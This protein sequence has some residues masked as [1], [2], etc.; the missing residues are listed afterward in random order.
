MTTQGIAGSTILLNTAERVGELLARAQGNSG[1]DKPIQILRP[2]IGIYL[3]PIII[4]T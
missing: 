1:L 2:N 3:S 4:I